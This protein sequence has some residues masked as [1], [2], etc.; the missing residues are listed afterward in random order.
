MPY[1]GHKTPVA[2]LGTSLLTI[3]MRRARC[4]AC[5]ATHVTWVLGKWQIVQSGL[6]VRRFTC[7]PFPQQTNRTQEVDSWLFNTSLRDRSP[8]R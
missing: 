5:F 3:T 1:A 7:G 4:E 8:M 2:V 6:R